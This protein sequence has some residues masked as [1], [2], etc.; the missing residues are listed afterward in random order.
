M[1]Q[2][3]KRKVKSVASSNIQNSGYSQAGASYKKRAFKN[4]NAHSF[5]AEWDIDFNNATLRQRA[6]ILYMSSPIAGSAVVTN[7]TNVIGCGLK[8]KS[9]IDG[10]ILGLSADECEDWQK[11]TEAEFNLWASKKN[12]C[13][14]TGI[15]DFYS[16]QQLALMG[17]LL[18]GDS[19]IAI[20]RKP[21]TLMQPYS[22]R[23]HVIEADRVSTPLM[24]T[25]SYLNI[26][27]GINLN[28]GNKIYDGVEV[29]SDGA[30]VAYHIC[31]H[32]PHQ[33]T[34][35]KKEWQRV[36]AYGQE[37]GLPNVLQIM[38]SERAEQYRGVS[39]LSQIIE[40]LL[41][42]RRYTESELT[43]ALV[44]SFFTAF[45]TTEADTDEGVPFNSTSHEES[46]SQEYDDEYQM[47][48]GNVNYMKPGE[49]VTLADPKR[50]S[51]GFDGFITSL[52]TQMGAALEIPTDL[53]LKKFNSSYSASRAALM[54]AWKAFK[55]RREWF[56]S[57]F[58]KPV[59]EIWLTEAIARGRI[60]APGFFTDPLV[61]E[62]WLQS[63]WVGPS[64]GQLDPV[65]EINAEILAIQHGFSTHEQ[66]TIK[67]NGGNWGAN[68]E[69]VNRENAKIIQENPVDTKTTKTTT[70]EEDEDEKEE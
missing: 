17:W 62:A 1:K 13:D 46:V 36:E 45:I 54:E 39:Y 49:S 3:K 16:I 69:Q 65:K 42:I 4:F 60:V 48:P 57:D 23:L 52:C 51:S 30:V 44:Q 31:N 5:N 67:L 66:S 6:R 43:A 27:T 50:P 28:T 47:G 8:L 25:N 22:L 21:S 59:Y 2:N 70:V 33:V 41:Q 15:N 55:M 35:D 53:L 12:N 37:L 26:T 11:K 19:F 64:Q 18:N 56:V 24:N 14:A 9:R 32:Y 7:R 63:D 40:P 58:C 61:H 20:K 10:R 68:I 29:D 38:N 34:L